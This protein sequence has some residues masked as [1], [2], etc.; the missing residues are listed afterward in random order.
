MRAIA[1]AALC[2][3][4][5]VDTSSH[6]CRAPCRG[7]HGAAPKVVP[8]WR[9]AGGAVTHVMDLRI[10]G[11]LN[12]LHVDATQPTQASRRPNTQ[13]EQHTRKGSQVLCLLLLHQVCM[14]KALGNVLWE[15]DQFQLTTQL[16]HF[17]PALCSLARCSNHLHTNA[18]NDDKQTPTH[19]RD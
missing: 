5:W 18:T 4:E 19:T 10:P 7:I 12:M 8:V 11:A 2:A 14:Q 13:Q 15:C 1:I 9:E 3:L 6:A 17:L 16:A